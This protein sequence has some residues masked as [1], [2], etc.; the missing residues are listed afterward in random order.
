MFVASKNECISKTARSFDMYGT[1]L[2]FTFEGSNKFSTCVGTVI[3]I[4]SLVLMISFT[5]NRSLKL[6]SADDPFFS[7]LSMTSQ[8]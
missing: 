7:S 5:V 3:T 6:V 2:N 4:F 8:D 1:T